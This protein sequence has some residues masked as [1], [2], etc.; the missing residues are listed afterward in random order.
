MRYFCFAIILLFAAYFCNCEGYA[1]RMT[2]EEVIEAVLAEGQ[3]Y[4][5]EEF[6]EWQ[7]W[8]VRTVEFQV[9]E[10]VTKYNKEYDNTEY[11]WQVVFQKEDNSRAVHFV[12]KDKKRELIG[13]WDTADT[14][15]DYRVYTREQSQFS[16]EDV[17]IQAILFKKYDYDNELWK[18]IR[19]VCHYS[20]RTTS[21]YLAENS[22]AWYAPYLLPEGKQIWYITF[23]SHEKG[24]QE[25]GLPNIEYCV[26]IDTKNGKVYGK[27]WTGQM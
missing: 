9:V 8:E 10:L 3:K 27:Y 7:T 1:P 25:H 18:H 23:C 11:V 6:D 4:F 21:S 15:V 13:G 22:Y 19:V 2:K 20:D 26:L 14:V 5:I 16:V 17:I 24:E 12:V